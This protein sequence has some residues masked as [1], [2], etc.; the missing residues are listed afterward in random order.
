MNS[1]WKTKHRK[2]DVLPAKRRLNFRSTSELIARRKRL[3]Q[4]IGVG[5]AL[6]IGVGLLLIE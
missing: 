4:Q 3:R 5:L 6:F 1:F 2:G